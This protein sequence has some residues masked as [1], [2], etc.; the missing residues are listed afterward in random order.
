VGTVYAR[1]AAFD[2]LPQL[3]VPGMASEF[4]TGWFVLAELYVAQGD[5]AQARAVYRELLELN[6]H[7]TTAAE[8]LSALSQDDD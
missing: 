7:L 1:P 8:A 4:Y 3:A 6:P 5:A 2:L